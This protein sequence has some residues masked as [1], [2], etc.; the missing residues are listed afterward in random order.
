ML[1]GCARI[2]REDGRLLIRSSA[3]PLAEAVSEHPEIC[4][5]VEA[6]VAELAGL[7]VR[8]RCDREKSPKC[9]F[10]VAYSE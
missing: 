6:L 3:C 2:E 9:C 10:E 8:E 7:P 5:L 1:G 4:E